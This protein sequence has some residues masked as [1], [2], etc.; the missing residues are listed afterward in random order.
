MAALHQRASGW[1][2]AEGIA[3][4]AFTHAVA[5]ADLDRAARLLDGQG[6]PLHFRGAVTP[7]LDW[8]ASLP[9]AELDAR[10]ALWVMFASAFR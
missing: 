2:E 8:L 5:A 9:T 1:F 4:E 7:V 3:L 10:P 6:M